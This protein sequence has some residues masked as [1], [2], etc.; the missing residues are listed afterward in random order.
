MES[1]ISNAGTMITI[2]ALNKLEK[3]TRE[4]TPLYSQ[5]DA[6]LPRRLSENR[7]DHPPTSAIKC[8]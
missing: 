6:Y 7:Q 8:E 1:G 2:K 4:N 3:K 5:L